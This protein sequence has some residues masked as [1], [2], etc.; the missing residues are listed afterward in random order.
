MITAII[1][2]RLGSTRFPGKVLEYFS[3]NTLLGHI[4]ERLKY[5]KHIRRII[6]ATT[7][8]KGDDI[9][10]DYLLKN[11][12]DY[13][14]GSEN[15]VLDRFYKASV[16]FNSEYILRV[17]SDDPFKDPK[18]IDD[19]IELFL[20]QNLD[21]A[22]NNNPVSFP[23]GLDVEVFTFDALK[24]AQIN[25]K[26]E[27]EREHITQYFYKNPH[28]FLQNNLKNEI[29][30]SNLRWTLDT[31]E[32]LKFTKEVYKRL[33]NN[34]KMFYFEDILKLLDN[35]PEIRLI[36]ANVKRSYLYNK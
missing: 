2:A 32:D 10:V 1:Q 19:V 5:S 4:I 29:N 15:D 12:I 9:L 3:G 7:E 28:L 21:F 11:N 27:F 14:R 8:S 34:N 23:E 13:F 17:T 31:Y 16:K 24:R 35:E 18:I 20:N 6:V 33:Y 26:N 30:Y 22:Y 25:A 36:N